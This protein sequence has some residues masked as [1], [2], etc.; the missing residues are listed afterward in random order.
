MSLTKGKCSA[1]MGLETKA[2]ITGEA[3]VWRNVDRGEVR[4]VIH[5]MHVAGRTNIARPDLYFESSV[6]TPFAGA[7]RITG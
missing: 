1:E 5:E 6:V 4:S 2:I 7:R 3:R